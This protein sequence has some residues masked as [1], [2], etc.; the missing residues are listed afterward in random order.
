MVW[1][2]LAGDF[3]G[4]ALFIVWLVLPV[5][6]LVVLGKRY[7][8]QSAESA[9]VAIWARDEVLQIHEEQEAGS[10]DDDADA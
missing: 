1:S 3:V 7:V 5:I 8:R 2:E 6:Y 4:I 10:Y 9:Q